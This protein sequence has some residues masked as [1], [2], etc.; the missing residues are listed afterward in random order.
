[1]SAAPRIGANH[2]LTRQTIDVGISSVKRLTGRRQPN[3]ACGVNTDQESVASG[4]ID[5]AGNG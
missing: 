5:G 1:M 4:V 2:H 3:Q